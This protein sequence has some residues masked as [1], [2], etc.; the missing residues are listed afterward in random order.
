MTLGAEQRGVVTLQKILIL[1]PDDG[2]A[3]GA[4]EV[5]GRLAEYMIFLTLVVL[6]HKGMAVR[7]LPAYIA[8]R[9]AMNEGDDL[10]LVPAFHTLDS[11]HTAHAGEG[12]ILLIRP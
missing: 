3:L 7:T 5:L 8:R 2:A 10:L 4:D 9:H 1:F 12:Q 11:P 6:D